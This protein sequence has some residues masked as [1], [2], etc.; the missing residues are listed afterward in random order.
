MNNDKNIP[1]RFDVRL[2][3]SGRVLADCVRL[4][5]IYGKEGIREMLQSGSGNSTSAIFVEKNRATIQL[6][7]IHIDDLAIGRIAMAMYDYAF[8]YKLPAGSSLEDFCTGMDLVED[9]IWN[10]QSEIYSLF[11]S[12]GYLMEDAGRA[13]WEALPTLCKH[14]RARI[15]LDLGEGV[16][17]DEVA[18]LARMSRRSVQNALIADGNQRLIASTT[19]PHQNIENETKY[20]IIENDEAKRWLKD[21]R[22]Y[23]PTKFVE[24]SNIPEAHPVALT[25]LMELGRY[26]SSR[27]KILEK[28]SESVADELGWSL[29]RVQYLKSLGDEPQHINPH[30]CED[31]AKSLLVSKEWFTEQVMKLLFPSQINLILK[32]YTD[33]VLNSSPLPVMPMSSLLEGNPKLIGDKICSRLVFVL[34]DGAKVFPVKMKNRA[35]KLLA[36]RVSAFGN[37]IEEAEE[38]EDEETMLDL[39]IS[40]G[41]AVRMTDGLGGQKSL[42]KKEGRSV[43]AVYLD[44]H[45]I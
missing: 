28:S 42:Y 19:S 31:L 5:E 12:D 22:E 43:R 13:G 10:F 30:D 38:I 39:V 40:K 15:R 14:A 27:W 35:T 29:D 1:S 25:T 2:E 16:F 18:M 41:Y 8:E 33:S 45:L 37:T 23:V 44:G 34:S 9:F 20:L 6:S 4:G 26:I 3:L 17:L 36:F 24:I 11:L 7:D 32:P 21:R